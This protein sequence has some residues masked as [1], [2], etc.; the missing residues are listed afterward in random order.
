MGPPHSGMIFGLEVIVKDFKDLSWVVLDLF[1]G[2]VSL[3][4]LEL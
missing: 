3:L 1:R 2:E 4:E